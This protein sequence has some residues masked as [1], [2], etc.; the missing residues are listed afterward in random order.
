MH[1]DVKALRTYVM[2][3]TRADRCCYVLYSI[4]SRERAQEHLGQGAV[5]Q[6]NDT[7]DAFTN[8]VSNQRWRLHSKK[9]LDPIAGSPAAGKS[10]AGI[11]N[12]FVDDRGNEME[13]RVLTKL[14]KYFQVGSRRLE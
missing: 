8:H 4:Q 1:L 5:A 9:T 3:P 12:L 13:Q 11:I 7:K 6:Q 2:I 10:V 14:T